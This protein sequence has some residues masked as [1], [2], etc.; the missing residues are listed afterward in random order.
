MKKAEEMTSRKI[1]WHRH[2]LPPNCMFNE[3]KGKHCII[4]EEPESQKILIA[5]YDQKPMGDLTKIERLAYAG[6]K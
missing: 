4:L 3:R 2:H 1:E 5:L 6:I